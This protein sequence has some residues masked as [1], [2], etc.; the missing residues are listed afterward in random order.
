MATSMTARILDFDTTKL[1]NAYGETTR[2][3]SDSIPPRVTAQH[4]ARLSAVLQ[5]TLDLGELLQLFF[6]EVSRSVAVS[7][8]SYEHKAYRCEH[9]L[10]DPSGHSTSY[11][12]QTKDDY[13]GELTFYRLKE[14]FQDKELAFLENLISCLV[15]PLRNG[16]RYQQAIRSALTDPLTGTGNRINMENVLDRE[17]ELAQRYHQSL[18]VLILDLDHFKAINDN[19]GHAAGDQVLKTVAQTL[20]ATSRCADTTFRYGGEE[21]VILLN[22]TD[23]NGARISAERLRATIAGLSCIYDSREIPITVSIGAATLRSGESKESFLKRA[24]MALYTAKQN[25]RNQVVLADDAAMVATTAI[26]NH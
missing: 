24:D 16:L 12:L 17:Y 1:V 5:T 7:G 21:F 13:L 20:R 4:L 6:A 14:R 15:Y 10:G 25:G 26:V 3:R 19:H 18:S 11:R 8:I 23:A 9:N 2:R 22:K